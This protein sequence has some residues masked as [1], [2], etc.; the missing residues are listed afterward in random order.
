MGQLADSS[1]QGVYRGGLA[2]SR[3]NMDE[4]CFVGPSSGKEYRP[5]MSY[6]NEC[7]VCLPRIFN[8]LRDFPRGCLTLQLGWIRMSV[9]EIG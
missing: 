8:Q 4:L 3:L 1:Q 7:L 9:L 6:L 2:R 5:S